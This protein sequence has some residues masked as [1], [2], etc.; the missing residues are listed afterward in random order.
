MPPKECEFCGHLEEMHN[1][2]TGDCEV[3]GC[4]CIEFDD[5]FI[6]L[7]DHPNQR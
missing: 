2:D 5:E 6:T 4:D 7:P 3:L 1:P